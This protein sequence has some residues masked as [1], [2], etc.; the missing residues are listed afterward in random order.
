MYDLTVLAVQ[1]A[2]YYAVFDSN[3]APKLRF[4]IIIT[5][6]QIL[7]ESSLV[8]PID[9]RF[10][11]HLCICIWLS[12]FMMSILFDFTLHYVFILARGQ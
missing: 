6:I 10:T 9:E 1:L 4:T 2:N 8:R 3:L 7:K 12:D 5:I 11:S